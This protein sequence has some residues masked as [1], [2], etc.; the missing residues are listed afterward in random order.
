MHNDAITGQ[1]ALWY[2]SSE[3]KDKFD[4]VIYV[5]NKTDQGVFS[6][7]SAS[8]TAELLYMA[9]SSPTATPQTKKGGRPGGAAS[10][11][12]LRG[13]GQSRARG[14]SNVGLSLSPL[15]GQIEPGQSHFF[16]SISSTC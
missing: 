6:H 13:Q 8:A 4:T 9:S 11:G 1:N 7:P 16:H 5:V 2:I 3:A 10:H 15:L 14:C 12:G